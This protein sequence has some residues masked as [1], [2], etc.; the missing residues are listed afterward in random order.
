MRITRD[1]SIIKPFLGA[2]VFLRQDE[3]G[4]KG[5]FEDATYE[6]EELLTD[7]VRIRF[8]ADV[9]VA[10]YLSGGF[11][12]S[13]TTA[14]IKKVAPETLQ[15]FSIG[16]EEWNLM[17]HL[18]NRKFQNFLNTS[19]LHLPVQERILANIFPR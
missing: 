8:R 11:D 12:S 5:S 3:P 9:P 1:K 14:L 10:A 7:A 18:I 6:L 4:F 13:A 15:T 17:R 19:I 16:F 2:H